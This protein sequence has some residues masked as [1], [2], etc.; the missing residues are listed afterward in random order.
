MPKNKYYVNRK[1]GKINE[2]ND[3]KKRKRKE[4]FKKDL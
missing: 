3:R 2:K 4:N 1:R